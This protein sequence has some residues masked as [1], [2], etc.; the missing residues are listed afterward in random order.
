MLARVCQG[1]WL[2]IKYIG[3]DSYLEVK[4]SYGYQADSFWEQV[5]YEEI[6]QH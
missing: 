5:Q 6:V 1:T 3:R 2:Y 4:F